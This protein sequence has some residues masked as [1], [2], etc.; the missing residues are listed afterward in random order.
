MNM[1]KN[2]LPVKIYSL[3]FF[4]I[5]FQLNFIP[6]QIVIQEEPDRLYYSYTTKRITKFKDMNNF[7]DVFHLDKYWLG[8]NRISGNISYNTGRILIVDSRGETLKEYRQALSFGTRIR[9]WEEFSINTNF[10]ID[11]N[12]KATAR[13]ISDYS[14]TIGRYNWKPNKFNFGYENYINNKYSDN[15]ATMAEKFLEGYYFV[16]YSHNLPEKIKHL[17]SLDGTT[18]IKLVYFVRYYI[19]YRDQFNETHGGI[20]SGKTTLGLSM[21]YTI[22]KNL[23]IEGAVYY[24]TN[25]AKRQPWDPDYTY[26]FGY[27]DWRSFRLYITYGNWAIN[28]FEANK[29]PYPQYGFLDGQF[30][31]VANWIW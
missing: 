27:F 2:F 19:K 31:I 11:F 25:P 13:W 24:Y 1:V 8:K 12:K 5:L 6:G 29:S 4:S 15:L 3:F 20:I 14:Y 21:R 10:F 18:N 28:R 30:R 23:Y 22:Y 9:F 16:S 17:I 26:G 7:R